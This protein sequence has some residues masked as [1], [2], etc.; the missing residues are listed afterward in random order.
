MRRP[1]GGPGDA[2]ELDALLSVDPREWEEELHDID[3]HY[4][5]FDSKLPEALREELEELK[6]RFSAAKR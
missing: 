5:Q 2:A 3:I 6:Q 4:T 1:G